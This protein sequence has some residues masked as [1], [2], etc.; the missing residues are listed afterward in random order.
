MKIRLPGLALTVTVCLFMSPSAFAWGCKG[1]QAVA[2]IAKKHLTPAAKALADQFLAVDPGRT[3]SGGCKT[4]GLDTYAAA[5]TWADAV[6][7]QDGVNDG[8]WHF[9]DIPRGSPTGSVISSI[10]ASSDSCI[11]AAIKA[12][13]DILEDSSKTDQQRA[14]A[15]R[16]IIHFAGDIHQ[17]LHCA[18]NG[19]KGGNCVPL[20]FFKDKP[21]PKK[22]HGQVVPDTYAP[23]LHGIWDTDMVEKDMTAAGAASAQAY[24]DFLDS[25]LASNILGWQAET[26]SE[27]D[28]AWDSF[29][30]SEDFAYGALPKLIPIDPHPDAVVK[31][32]SDNNRIGN[33]MFHK[34]LRVGQVYQDDVSPIIQERL[35]M[36]GIRLAMLLNDAATKVH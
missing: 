18:N 36:A 31:V 10:C 32:C 14:A 21:N 34:H 26:I 35:A 7:G 5:S 29:Q 23:D 19:D 20:T 15:V 6:R 4:T 33:R 11:V 24:A 2:L 1:H 28:W 22:E 8:G 25:K 17:P 27:E 12:Q 16:Y 13:L 30:H 3:L 9:V